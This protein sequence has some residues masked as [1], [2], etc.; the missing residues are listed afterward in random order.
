MNKE[1]KNRYLI[2]VRTILNTF[3]SHKKFLD[4]I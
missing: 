3:I 1:D 2:S 4:F